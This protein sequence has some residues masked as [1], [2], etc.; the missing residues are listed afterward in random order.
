M[1]SWCRKCHDFHRGSCPFDL[2]AALVVGLI[3]MIL[4]AMAMRG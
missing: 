4:L 1:A 2:A 3:I